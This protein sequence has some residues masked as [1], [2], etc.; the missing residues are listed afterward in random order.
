MEE[1]N[2]TFSYL[3]KKEILEQNILENYEDNLSEFIGYFISKNIE[4]TDKKTGDIEVYEYRTDNEYNIEHLHRLL[5]I[6]DISANI[7][8]YGSIFILEFDI[9]KSFRNMIF[10]RIKALNFNI[11]YLLKGLFLGSGYISISN[12]NFHFEMSLR[13]IDIYKTYD[14]KKIKENK[15]KFLKKIKELT[16]LDFKIKNQDSIYLK[17]LDDIILITEIISAD[18]AYLKLTEIKITNE[19]NNDINR[20][21]NAST[22]NYTKTIKA[23]E[24][25]IDIINKLKK[26]NKLNNLNKEDKKIIEARLKYKEY[27]LKE[28]ANHLK[29]PKSTL[30]S[31][32]KK[33]ENMEN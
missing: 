27:S 13:D 17:K 5:N 20:S 10:D 6:L 30:Y 25:Q 32:L 21:I 16:S 24:R 33:I 29:I 2:I 8:T 28:L 4:K 15:E 18:K 22:A 26:E 3:T 23:S 19:V 31:K 1:K 11:N 12:N 14:R 9:A 7:Y